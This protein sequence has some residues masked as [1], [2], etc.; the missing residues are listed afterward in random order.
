MPVFSISFSIYLQTSTKRDLIDLHWPL[1]R[2]RL[3]GTAELGEVAKRSGDTGPFHFFATMTIESAA[4]QHAVVDAICLAGA[5]RWPWVVS[6][7][8]RDSDGELEQLTLNYIGGVD[9]PTGHNPIT[10][11]ELI[12]FPAG[13]A[14]II[15]SGIVMRMADGDAD[16]EEPSP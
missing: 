7:L 10:S 8:S 15:N 13:S 4:W 14:Q 3:G 16:P 2:Q 9:L 6:E 5:I 12:M 11:A 1:I